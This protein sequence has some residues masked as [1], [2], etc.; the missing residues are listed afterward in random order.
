MP[1]RGGSGVRLKKPCAKCEEYFR[2]ATKGTTLC[3]K[4]FNDSQQK[5]KEKKR[6]RYN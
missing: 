1:K 2:P 6:A 4:C 5:S 3:D